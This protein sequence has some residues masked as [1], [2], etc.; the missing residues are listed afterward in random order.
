MEHGAGG[1]SIVSVIECTSCPP[2][3]CALVYMH[4]VPETRY[5]ISETSGETT[6]VFLSISI[7]TAAALK[8][9]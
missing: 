6:A 2:A 8:Y 4:M 9:V 7:T 5:Q 1:W 3:L